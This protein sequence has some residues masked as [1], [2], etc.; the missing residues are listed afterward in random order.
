[1]GRRC[2][3]TGRHVLLY[4]SKDKEGMNMPELKVILLVENDPIRC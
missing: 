2:C 1:V 4:F 3:R